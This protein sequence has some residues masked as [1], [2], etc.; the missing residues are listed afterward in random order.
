MPPKITCFSV[1]AFTVRGPAGSSSAKRLSGSPSSSDSGVV[2]VLNVVA[3]STSDGMLNF[4]D[5][6][7]DSIA[8][9]DAGRA[10]SD[11]ALDSSDVVPVLALVSE[12][13]GS[14]TTHSLTLWRGDVIV[15]G[16]RTRTVAIEGERNDDGSQKRRRMAPPKTDNARGLAI[17]VE[18]GVT[19]QVRGKEENKCG[20]GRSGGYEGGNGTTT[21]TGTAG[22]G[23]GL[24]V[25]AA[26]SQQQDVCTTFLSA[27]EKVSSVMFHSP[28]GTGASSTRKIIAS[29]P[30]GTLSIY[31][32]KNG[33]HIKSFNLPP[34]YSSSPPIAKSGLTI[35]V[36]VGPDVLFI[37]V[38]KFDKIVT[39]CTGVPGNDVLSLAF[40]ALSPN[41]LYVGLTGGDVLVFN[42][43]HRPQADGSAALAASA[44][45]AGGNVRDSSSSNNAATICK[46]VY[47][48]PR[49]PSARRSAAPSSF[50]VALRGYVLVGGAKNNAIVVWNAT[51]VKDGGARYMF[52]SEGPA[53]AT[54]IYE[55]WQLASS[56]GSGA[57]IDNVLFAVKES[58]ERITIFSHLLPYAPPNSD[59]TWMRVPLIFVGIFIVF[60]YNYVKKNGVPGFGRAGRRGMPQMSP[61]ELEAL[62]KLKGVE[63]FNMAEFEKY[64]SKGGI[65]GLGGG[66]KAQRS[67]GFGGGKEYGGQSFGGQGFGGRDAG[68]SGR[69]LGGGNRSPGERSFGA[70]PNS[71][72]FGAGGM[73]GFRPGAAGFGQFSGGAGF[74]DD[75]AD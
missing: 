73:G 21:A 43:K 33:T 31:H 67:P 5:Q 56:S 62:G 38:V 3:V 57:K 46:L 42:T 60:G 51:T 17:L 14:V 74:E 59:V 69:L 63:G 22:A 49:P 44:A 23:A 47:K 13:G 53:E 29:T 25:D 48:A 50:L 8:S 35:A 39:T 55:K 28:R 1:L 52:E 66:G 65:G 75:E 72:A 71:R 7:G 11:V 16:P 34:G 4:Y 10:L 58:D 6:T 19:V 64:M 2:R 9:F 30:D 68:A 54:Q 12:S 26:A 70:T 32:A 27:A 24:D 36:G 15:A 20:S 37:N 45:S 18:D 41:F 61:A 40:D